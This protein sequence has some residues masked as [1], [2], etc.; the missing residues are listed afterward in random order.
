[1]VAMIFAPR[2]EQSERPSRVPVKLH[3]LW[4]TCA[5]AGFAVTALVA[6]ILALSS[7]LPGVGF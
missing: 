3:L 1:M 6:C 5:A 7:M 4:L 2:S